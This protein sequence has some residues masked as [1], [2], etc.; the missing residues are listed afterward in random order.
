MLR[1]GCEVGWSSGPSVLRLLLYEGLDPIQQVVEPEGFAHIVID[2]RCAG[3]ADI[4]SR[5]TRSQHEDGGFLAQAP[6]LRRD[7]KP[8]LLW[9][10]EVQKNQVVSAGAGELDGLIS[11]V[12]PVYEKPLLA[13][14]LL[15]ES[16]HFAIVLDQQDPHLRNPFPPP[17]RKN[18]SFVLHMHFIRLVLF[19][20][21]L[22]K[23]GMWYS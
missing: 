13:K 19:Y 9:Q 15:K 12:R 4:L 14:A 16:A 7:M 1:V 22:L 5:I 2:T 3:A 11:V 6:D 23:R 8:V 17:A 10:H 18:A 21:R 20:L